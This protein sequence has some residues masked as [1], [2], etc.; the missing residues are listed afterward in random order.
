MAKLNRDKD[1]YLLPWNDKMESVIY[2]DRLGTAYCH[3]CA[4]NL[5]KS[6]KIRAEVIDREYIECQGCFELRYK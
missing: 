1:G 4:S 3:E 6:A 2:V 5:K